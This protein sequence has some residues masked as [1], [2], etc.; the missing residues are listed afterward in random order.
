VI[1]NPR[2]KSSPEIAH[3]NLT[4]RGIALAC[5]INARSR[6]TI[7]RQSRK[8]VAGSSAPDPTPYPRPR[9]PGGAGGMGGR[10]KRKRARAPRGHLSS[11]YLRVYVLGAFSFLMKIY[12]VISTTG[13]FI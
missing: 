6:R 10:K 9:F 8:L 11:Y 2:R 1:F 5:L 4:S 3:R 12:Y 13:A 7:S